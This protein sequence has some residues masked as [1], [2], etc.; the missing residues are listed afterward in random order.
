MIDR[1]GV[2]ADGSKAIDR[3]EFKKI[4]KPFML[5]HVYKIED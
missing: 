5:D 2:D 1:P 4:M 3:G